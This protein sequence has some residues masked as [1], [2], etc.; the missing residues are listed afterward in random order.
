MSALIRD[1]A[2]LDRGDVASA[3]GKAASLGHLIHQGYRVPPGFVVTTDAFRRFLEEAELT[4]VVAREL[5]ELAVLGPAGAGGAA[6]RLQAH[7]AS[8]AWPSVLGDELEAMLA[9]RPDVCFAVRSSASMEDGPNDSW[10]GQLESYL[11][12]DAADVRGAIQRAWG[13]LFGERALRYGMTRGGGRALAA[14]AMAV[15]VQQMVEAD[16]AGVGFS[17]HPV[18]RTAGTMLIEAVHGLGEAAVD[19]GVTPDG[20][21]LARD[22]LAL[23][24]RSPHRQTRLRQRAPTGGTEWAPLPA[25]ERGR[26][27]L[28]PTELELL[29]GMLV[30]LAERGGHEVDVEWAIAEGQ[31]YLL[32]CRPITSLEQPLAT[33]T[34]AASES[35]EPATALH[36]IDLAAVPWRFIHRRR[37]SPFFARLYFG[38][39]AVLAN[40]LGF[41]Y[42]LDRLGIFLDQVA[43]DRAEWEA[44]ADRLGRKF[45]D[46]LGWFGRA[47]MRCHQQHAAIEPRWAEIAAVDWATAGR[48]AMAATLE[49]YV[50]SCA[51]F[52]AHITW[53]PVAEEELVRRLEAGLG[54][55]RSAAAAGEGFA[56]ASDPVRP[57]AVLE[58]RLAL[59]AIAAEL[60]DGR[61]VDDALA[62]HAERFGWMRN[63]GYFGELHRV[64]VYRREAEK[65]A[66]GTP[67]ET[68]RQLEL[69]Q[70][71]KRQ[72]LSALLDEIGADTPLAE[73]VRIANELVH[74]RSYR[75]EIFYRSYVS[76]RG[77]LGAIASTLAI[78]AEDLFY[79]LPEELVAALQSGEPAPRDVVAA[80]RRGY[81]FLTDRVLGHL[82]YSGADAIQHCPQIIEQG[83]AAC[84]ELQG[85]AAFAGKVR[86]RVRIVHTLADLDLVVPG[87]VMVTHA[88]NIDYLSALGR[89]AAFVTEEGGILCHAAV[90]SRELGIPAVLG[91]GNATSILCTGD[92]VEV[93]ATAGVVRRLARAPDGSTD[94]GRS[95]SARRDTRTDTQEPS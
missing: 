52:A 27:V 21:E 85:Q 53:P 40:D 84:D 46:D 78:D 56:V 17:I 19:G 51:V 42:R 29:G 8:S 50:S 32:Q 67:R 38:G 49:E 80:R 39:A 69:E 93:D 5:A 14:P 82:I 44:L 90:V 68:A 24:R 1:L 37:R 43:C 86:G 20:Y 34:A 57:S 73:L 77:L 16:R 26:A 89:V 47:V 10:A 70:A 33:P 74:F 4:E 22:G 58:E 76:V 87:D 31:I 61:P 79:L 55:G 59:L 6:A 3:G 25:A 9:R 11:W 64:E 94:L 54:T 41:D 88:T 18:D 95:R 81:L 92:I 12:L 72:R 35:G 75:A 15:V 91:T 2:E 45:E 7:I 66:V 30:A 63:V 48:H 62:R 36:P 65:A 60:R 83:Q 28:A 23:V 13:S 71:A